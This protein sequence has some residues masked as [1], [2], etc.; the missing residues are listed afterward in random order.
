MTLAGGRIEAVEPATG[1]RPTRP[2]TLVPGF[3]DLQVNGI[4]AVDVATARDGD[5]DRLDAALLAQGVTAWCPTLVSAPLDTYADPLAHIA[6]AAA[7]PAAGRPAVLGAHLEGP[8]LGDRH[9]AHPDEVVVGPDLDW[10][11]ALPE[12]VRLVTL[13]PEAPGALEAV[14]LL[15]A[16]GCLVAVGHTAATPAVVTAAVDA[17]ARLFTHL[18][19][20]SG[21][22]GARDPGPVGAALVEDRLAV[23]LIADLVHV[24]PVTLDLVLRAK[25]AD[26]VVLVTDAVAWDSPWARQRGVTVVDG[27]PRLA[28]GTLAGSALTMDAAVRHLVAHTG[29]D[30]ATAV[31]AASTTPARLLGEVDRGR[32]VPGARADL[33]LLDEHL[34]VGEVWVGGVPALDP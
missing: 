17:G 14:R 18:F 3:V 11:A 9:G 4:G 27:A 20:G 5:W 32:I 24:D 13:G 7:R 8:F 29:A 31:R 33:V 25:P 15:A 6:R 26:G 10:L 12:V 21:T 22:V 19:N 1:P 34:E 16:R 28:D 30:L 23:S 2:G